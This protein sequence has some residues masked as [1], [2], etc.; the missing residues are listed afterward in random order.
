MC[1]RKRPTSCADTVVNVDQVHLLDTKL[2]SF[3]DDFKDSSCSLRNDERPRCVA[4]PCTHKCGFL[5]SG[6]TPDVRLSA[7]SGASRRSLEVGE[8]QLPGVS[9]PGLT[10]SKLVSDL[11]QECR[12]F[13]WRPKVSYALRRGHFGDELPVLRRNVSMAA[14]YDLVA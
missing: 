14:R 1:L 4:R 7:D 9:S 5:G 2:F 11:I 12:H 8:S 3:D 10:N 6:G 13:T